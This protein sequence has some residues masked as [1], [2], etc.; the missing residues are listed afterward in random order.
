MGAGPTWYGEIAVNVHSTNTRNTDAEVSEK[1]TA[2][3]LKKYAVRKGSGGRGHFNGGDGTIREIEARIPLKF[4]IL[5][6]RRVYAPYGM[7]GGRPGR[8]GKNYVFKFSIE[9]EGERNEASGSSADDKTRPMKKIALGGKA[10][11][12]LEPGEIMQINTPGGGGW[13]TPER[14]DEEDDI[15][16]GL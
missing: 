8:R 4:S 6:D 10:V 2:V 3:I 5:S 11:V 1:R 13:G 7:N 12:N 14:L 16:R 9:E 15:D